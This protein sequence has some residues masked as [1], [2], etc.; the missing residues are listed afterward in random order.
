MTFVRNFFVLILLCVMQGKH[1]I[2][3]IPIEFRGVWITSVQNL[4]WPRATD[5]NNAENQKAHLIEILDL[6]E[7]LNFNAVFLQVRTECD[8]FYKSEYEPY[9]RFLTG[10]QGQD[11]QY[12]PLQFAIDECRK[13]GLEIHAWLN[14]YRVNALLKDKDNYYDSL[15]ISQIHPEWI[16]QYASGQKILNPAEPA[17]Q[18]YIAQIVG[19]LVFNYDIDGIHF[20]DYFY[21]YSGTPDS[22]DRF[23][24]QNYGEDYKTIGEFRRAAINKM[25]ALVYDTIKSLKPFVKFGIS[26]FGIYGNNQ[27]PKGIKGTDA[28]HTLY[29]DPINWMQNNKVDYICPQLY[30]TTRGAQ[31]YYKLLQWWASTASKYKTDLFVGHAIY[32]IAINPK[33]K[34]IKRTAQ[35][36]RNRLENLF[37]GE[38]AKHADPWELQQLRKQIEIQRSFNAK[39]VAGSVFFRF[40]FIKSIAGFS[41]YISTRIFPQKALSPPLCVGNVI[42]NTPEIIKITKLEN[43]TIR[44]Q[45]KKNW[46]SNIRF[47]AVIVNRQNQNKNIL[48]K[49]FDSDMIEIPMSILRN[50]SL[51]IMAIDRFS[52]LSEMVIVPI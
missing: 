42:L 10:K 26:P 30:W 35:K 20:D 23:Q 28:Y 8:A 48:Y 25:V 22:L 29:C 11:P 45:L 7:K 9:S 38:E 34:R 24:F 41:D 40:Q 3:Q 15:H 43:K 4:D 5:K 39:G 37:K 31:D 51:A 21:S 6:I 2:S 33:E 1:G 36:I 50:K 12:D 27:M 19:D 44:I 32:K 13:R 47:A 18:K 17:V 52:N 14:P 49:V 46:D 16:L